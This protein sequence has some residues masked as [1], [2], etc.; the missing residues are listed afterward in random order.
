M[1]LFSSRKPRIA[2]CEMCGKSDAEGCGA[3][4]KHVEEI[5]GDLPTWLPPHLRAQAQ[6][7]YTWICVRCNSYPAMKWPRG[8]GASAG[9]LIHL[10]GAHNVGDMKGMG[11]SSG[12]DMIRVT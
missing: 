3:L 10:G 6:G 12:F 1:P 5:S 2:V 8:S 9:M 11:G 7:E 4:Y